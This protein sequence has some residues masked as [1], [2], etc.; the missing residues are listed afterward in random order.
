MAEP[1]ELRWLASRYPEGPDVLDLAVH[2]VADSNRLA[3]VALADLDWLPAAPIVSGDGERREAIGAAGETTSRFSGG[4]TCPTTE[5]SASSKSE[6]SVRHN[7][8]TK[9]GATRV[10]A[11]VHCV[12]RSPITP[13]CGSLRQVEVYYVG[14]ALIEAKG[15]AAH[16][17]LRDSGDELGR[18]CMHAPTHVHIHGPSGDGERLGTTFD[19][20]VRVNPEIAYQTAFVSA[21]PLEVTFASRPS[22]CGEADNGML[23]F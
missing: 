8:P 12:L 2:G 7:S 15:L 14:R 1:G 10:S 23:G 22:D 11:Y 5:S 17:G 21:A 4:R 9:R 6:P 13:D 20:D 3:S 19:D 18:S 16:A